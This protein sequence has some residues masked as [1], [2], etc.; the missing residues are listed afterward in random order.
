MRLQ[1]CWLP[2]ANLYMSLSN[3]ADIIRELRGVCVFPAGSVW[4][5]Q[6]DE[7]PASPTRP[8]AL[9]APFTPRRRIA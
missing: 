9:P 8:T 6:L 5:G 3:E 4:L 2:G 7:S 1:H